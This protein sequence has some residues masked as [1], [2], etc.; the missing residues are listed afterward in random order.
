MKFQDAKQCNKEKSTVKQHLAEFLFE[1]IFILKYLF[2]AE[3]EI[4]SIIL[5]FLVL[6]CSISIWTLM[7]NISYIVQKFK[8]YDK[9]LL[10]SWEFFN[11]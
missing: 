9:I 1:Y 2:P 5:F 7:S 4:L 10:L 3:L 8:V 11:A 6:C